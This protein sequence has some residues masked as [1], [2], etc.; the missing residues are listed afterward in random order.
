MSKLQ[1]LEGLKQEYEHLKNQIRGLGVVAQGTVTERTILRLNPEDRRK[2]KS[3]GPYYQ[4]TWK[5]LGRTVTV[6]LTALQARKF[7]KAIATHR[8]LERLLKEMRRISLQIIE[9][10]IPGVTQ[11][12]KRSNIHSLS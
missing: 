10:S 8:K 5:K 2:R 9:Q 4:W 12:K 3:Y 1:S 7:Q 6:N 11:R